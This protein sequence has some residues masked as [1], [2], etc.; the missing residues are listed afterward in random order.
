MEDPMENC[1]VKKWKEN[2][3][4]L[5]KLAL[6]AACWT[7]PI[8]RKGFKFHKDAPEAHKRVYFEYRARDRYSRILE[9]RMALLGVKAPSREDVKT[10]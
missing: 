4:E 8:T 6:R 9:Y 5:R 7:I 2:E 1:L 10:Y 3:K